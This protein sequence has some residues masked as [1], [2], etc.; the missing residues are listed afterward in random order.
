MENLTWHLCIASVF[1]VYGSNLLKPFNFMVQCLN[2]LH[3]DA[4]VDSLKEMLESWFRKMSYSIDS[5]P[6]QMT[7]QLNSFEIWIF[8]RLSEFERFFLPSTSNT[9][10]INFCLTFEFS[11]N[12]M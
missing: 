7:G 11:A 12:L 4:F 2:L 3:Q 10:V 6:F 9:K 5:D 1:F 8:E